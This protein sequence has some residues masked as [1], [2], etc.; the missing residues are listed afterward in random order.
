MPRTKKI[1]FTDAR[2]R[3]EIKYP[4]GRTYRVHILIGKQVQETVLLKH[5][6]T[7]LEDYGKIETLAMLLGDLGWM[8]ALEPEQRQVR[9][10]VEPIWQCAEEG[11]DREG[12]I[13]DPRNATFPD[14]S[15]VPFD[16]DSERRCINHP[17]ES[18]R[19]ALEAQGRRS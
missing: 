8:K 9:Y 17:P 15:L 16:P 14:G 2:E 12:A 10:L 13:P 11:C 7:A 18:A 5:D 19:R 6:A 1:P 3:A 4:E